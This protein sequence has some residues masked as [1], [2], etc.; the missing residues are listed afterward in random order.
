MKKVFVLLF[1]IVFY[2][3]IFTVSASSKEDII[4]LED[5]VRIYNMN[6][7]FIFNGLMIF[8]KN[9]MKGFMDKEGNVIIEPIFRDIKLDANGEVCVVSI[10]QKNG[11]YSLGKRRQ[12]TGIK[13]DSIG[14]F[15][16][17]YAKFRIGDREG[18]LNTDGK[19]FVSRLGLKPLMKNGK[20]AYVDEKG[21]IQIKPE[22]DLAENFI[23]GLAIVSK[24]YKQGIIDSK[25]KIVLPLKYDYISR[26]ANGFE[27]RNGNLRGFFFRDSGLVIEPRYNATGTKISDGMLWVLEGDKYSFLNSSGKQAFAGEYSMIKDFSDGLAGVAKLS[28]YDFEGVTVN[29]YKY[30]FID[31]TGKLVIEYRYEDCSVFSEGLNPIMQNLSYGF[32]DKT[33]KIIIPAKYDWASS[34]SDGMALLYEDGRNGLLRN[35]LINKERIKVE[36][37]S[38]PQKISVDDN[39]I[40]ELEVYLYKGRNYFKLRDIAKLARS[41]DSKFSVDWIEEKALISIKKGED[42]KEL[43]TELKAGDGK[44]KQGI[45]S[46][47]E[48]E[49][50]GKKVFLDAYNIEGQTYYQIR[51]LG[52]ALGFGVDWDASRRIVK[53]KMEK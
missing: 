48:V 14:N 46:S 40:D 21:R 13:Y 38:S 8:G 29:G 39:I 4:W 23:D 19:E 12:I 50:D 5:G 15:E 37:M 1:S 28:I 49:V 20:Y 43:G 3:S 36:L 47:F 18:F 42:Y 26:K 45:H 22:Y 31:K 11:L 53:I 51:P 16:G 2:T 52:R 24:G 7:K 30:G 44:N 27:L 33:G 6:D 25:G 41:T 17:D 35:P 34:F 9:G 32:I 10:G